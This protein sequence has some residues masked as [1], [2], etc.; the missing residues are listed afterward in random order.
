MLNAIV[1]SVRMQKRL[2]MRCKAWNS[3]R[4]PEELMEKMNQKMCREIHC[5]QQ[6]LKEES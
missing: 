3:K 5:G 6:G 2:L 4:G 1:E